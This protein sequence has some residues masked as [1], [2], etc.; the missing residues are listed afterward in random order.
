MTSHYH[1]EVFDD[2]GKEALAKGVVVDVEAVSIEEATD[3]ATRSYS[4]SYVVVTPFTS[5]P[6][7]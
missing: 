7:N 4:C 5:I 6:N 2:R 1:V 3:I